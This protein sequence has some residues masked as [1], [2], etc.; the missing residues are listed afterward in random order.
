M[1]LMKILLAHG[2]ST[3]DCRPPLSY[4]RYRSPFWFDRAV[5]VGK[6][7]E[8]G[9]EVLRAEWPCCNGFP[10][11]ADRRRATPRGGRKPRSDFEIS[12]GKQWRGLRESN[13][14]SQRERLVS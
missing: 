12:V 7:S 14:S 3:T 11:F 10:L 5:R 6:P 1:F 4:V 2:G 13:P 8:D 9:G